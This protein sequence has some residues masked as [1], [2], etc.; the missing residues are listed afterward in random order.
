VICH[1]ECHI[2]PPQLPTTMM[3][4]PSSSDFNAVTSCTNWANN[5]NH[6]REK[7]GDVNQIHQEGQDK[8]NKLV[9]LRKQQINNQ[10]QTEKKAWKKKDLRMCI[11]IEPT[12]GI[13][14]I[15]KTNQLCVLLEKIKKLIN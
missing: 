5:T 2:F 1:E 4:P 15:I 3:K 11:Y 14:K 8:Q 9:S 13:K 6:F 10:N 12:R 7:E